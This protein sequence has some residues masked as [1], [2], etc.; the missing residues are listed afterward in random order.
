MSCWQLPGVVRLGR[1]AALVFWP[2][3][4]SCFTKMELTTDSTDVTDFQSLRPT[5]GGHEGDFFL[6][7]LVNLHGQVMLFQHGAFKFGQEGEVLVV[8]GQGADFRRAGGGQVALQLEDDEGRA[9]AHAEF[10]LLLLEG[11]FGVFAGVAGGLGLGEI[12]VR[13]ARWCSGF[14]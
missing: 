3:I 10:L 9:G 4:S 2:L 14:G 7:P 13:A 8:V 11:Q 5:E 12:A 1:A 6:A